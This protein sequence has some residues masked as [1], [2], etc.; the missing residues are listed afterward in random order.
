MDANA[1]GC[2]AVIVKGA[3]V[4]RIAVEGRAAVEGWPAVIITVG[5]AVATA[6]ML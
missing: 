3:A 6:W 5:G 1:E 4:D 2:P